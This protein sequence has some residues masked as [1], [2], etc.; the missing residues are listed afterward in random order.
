MVVGKI[1][2]LALNA[3][4]AETLVLATRLGTMALALRS[5]ADGKAADT[6]EADSPGLARGGIGIVRFGQSSR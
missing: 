4:N 2:T 1:A 5:M 3:R 6:E